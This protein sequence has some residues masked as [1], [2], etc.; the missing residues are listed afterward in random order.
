MMLLGPKK[1][2]ASIIIGKMKEKP[3][4]KS[5]DFVQKLGESSKDAPVP[6][7]EK[8]SEP[9]LASA[10]DSFIAAVKKEDSGAAVTAMK[11]FFYMCQEESSP[12]SSPEA[13]E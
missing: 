3:G 1:K 2:I 5:P 4:S 9:G 12:E 10:M 13:E 8:D 11:D 7:V 6:E